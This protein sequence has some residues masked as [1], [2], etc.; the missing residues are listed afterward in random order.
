M[1]LTYR[2]LPYTSDASSVEPNTNE[3]TGQYRGSTF[4]IGT[5]DITISNSATSLRYRGIAYRCES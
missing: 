1:Q 3:M 2:G 5:S 4:K